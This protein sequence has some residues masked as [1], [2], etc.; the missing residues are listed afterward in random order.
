MR[1]LSATPLV[2][3]TGR[4]GLVPHAIFEQHGIA[5]VWSL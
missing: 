1:S 5:Q 4:H 3:P 2:A